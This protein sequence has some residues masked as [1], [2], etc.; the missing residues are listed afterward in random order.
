MVE[1]KTTKQ[2][3]LATLRSF[4]LS[5]ENNA[6]RHARTPLPVALVRRGSK[7]VHNCFVESGLRQTKLGKPAQQIALEGGGFFP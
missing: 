4:A 2:P 1:E 3:I 6:S 7:A 5:V